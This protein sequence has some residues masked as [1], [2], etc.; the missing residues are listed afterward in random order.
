MSFTRPKSACFL[1]PHSPPS[2]ALQSCPAA[3]VS[4]VHFGRGLASG[5]GSKLELQAIPCIL[6]D[7]GCSDSKQ[8]G[9]WSN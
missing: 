2:L 5:L 7:L 1:P 8:A 9:A 6:S 4:E 3:S